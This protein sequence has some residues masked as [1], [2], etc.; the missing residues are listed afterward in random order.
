MEGREDQN[1]GQSCTAKACIGY[2]WIYDFGRE[3]VLFTATGIVLFSRA[4]V[5]IGVMTLEV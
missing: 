4:L 5:P 1:Q 3:A 2:L